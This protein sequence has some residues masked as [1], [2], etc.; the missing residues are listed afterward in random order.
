LVPRSVCRYRFS[1]PEFV[2]GRGFGATGGDR[3]RV[4]SILSRTGVCF[5]VS[6]PEFVSPSP[7]S[8]PE[9]VFGAGVCLGRRGFG[10]VGRSVSIPELVSC[11]VFSLRPGVES[12]NTDHY[13]VRPRL[14]TARF[15][16]PRCGIRVVCERLSSVNVE[17]VSV[18][19]HLCLPKG[20]SAS[21][22]AL[23]LPKHARSQSISV[24]LSSRLRLSE[25][26]RSRG[27]CRCRWETRTVRREASVDARRSTPRET[28]DTRQSR[29]CEVPRRE[30]RTAAEGFCV[31]SSLLAN[32]ST[33]V[34]GLHDVR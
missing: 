25:L 4:V 21:L 31:P 17:R 23:R 10:A 13:E 19:R 20:H 34:E 22:A 6:V 7:V 8:V 30:M 27:A 12:I 18:R 9:F 14:D 5:S 11:D 24:H 33:I 32:L 29:R 2:L 15:H 16:G 3:I 28:P 1:V 26:R